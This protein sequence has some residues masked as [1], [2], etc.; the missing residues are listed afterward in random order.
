MCKH[1][2][3]PDNVYWAPDEDHSEEIFVLRD[4]LIQCPKRHSRTVPVRQG[5][6][7][8]AQRAGVKCV[9]CSLS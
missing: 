5:A 1:H 9:R 6:D 4:M 8:D 2:H 7:F 3:S